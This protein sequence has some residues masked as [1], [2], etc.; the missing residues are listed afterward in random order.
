MVV[1]R[2][3][4]ARGAGGAGGRRE[5]GHS[6]AGGRGHGRG[7]GVVDTHAGHEVGDAVVG[8]DCQELGDARL[9]VQDLAVL[10]AEHVLPDLEVTL[11][12]AQG[13]EQIHLDL[14]L[15]G[16]GVAQ[17]LLLLLGLLE[18]HHQLVIVHVLPEPHDL[19]L[20]GA[21]S[22]LGP[23]Q[24][25]P[26]LPDLGLQLGHGRRI[27]GLLGGLELRLDSLLLVL[28][29]GLELHLEI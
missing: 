22:L 15:A 7:A 13:R 20:G 9:Q 1:G 10:L 27:L 25:V 18:L 8:A 16:Q 26:Q 11:G 12:H 28:A 19:V 2:E 17:L 6:C 14:G 29:F 4:A 5:A 3:E 24:L 23:R 21:G